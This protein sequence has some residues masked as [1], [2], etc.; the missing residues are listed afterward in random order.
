MNN[1][2]LENA[3]YVEFNFVNFIFR[4]IASQQTRLELM[5]SGAPIFI[6]HSVKT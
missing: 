3:D 2:L 4:K 6:R 5:A 1:N